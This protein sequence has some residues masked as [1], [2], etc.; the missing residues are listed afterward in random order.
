MYLWQVMRDKAS[1]DTGVRSVACCMKNIMGKAVASF[2]PHLLVNA[3]L[4]EP[5]LRKVLHV[6][7]NLERVH[8]QG[9]T[10]TM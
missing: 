6:L 7:L 8:L 1:S 10:V 9:A 5:G 4:L 3:R 2:R